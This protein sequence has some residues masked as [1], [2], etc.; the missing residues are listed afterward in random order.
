MHFPPESEPRPLG[1]ETGSSYLIKNKVAAA[2][3]GALADPDHPV[4]LQPDEVMATGAGERWADRKAWTDAE[5]ETVRGMLWV[6]LGVSRERIEEAERVAV[7]TGAT[8]PPQEV[9]L[10]GYPISLYV[11]Y[12]PFDSDAAEHGSY[13][14]YSLERQSDF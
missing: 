8:K 13:I 2:I 12:L 11:H 9:P 14:A 10:A 1:P 7:M 4:S 3:D 5:R 6:K